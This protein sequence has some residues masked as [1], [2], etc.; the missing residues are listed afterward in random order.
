MEYYVQCKL[1]NG[2]Y[3]IVAF[4]PEEGAAVGSSMFLKEDK[5]SGRWV[6]LEVYGTSKALK[7]DVL[8]K[9]HNVFDSIK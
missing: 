7:A 3:T 5:A 6:V 4:I 2:V 9:R 8:N 1:K